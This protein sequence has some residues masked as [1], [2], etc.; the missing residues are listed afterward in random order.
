M[1][2]LFNT[3][4]YQP[5]FNA[6]ILIYNYIP[7][8]GITIIIL[9]IILKLI[10]WPLTKKSLEG[11][12]ALQTLQP[13]MQEIK[14]KYK[15]DKM[16]QSQA[17]MELYKTEKINPA[18]SCLPMLIQLPILW[19]VFRVFRNGFKEESM[20]ALYSFV[21]KP[22][23]LNP[24]MLNLSFFDLSKPNYLFAVLAGAAQYWQSKMMS[25]KQPPKNAGDGS[26]DEMMTSMMN[27][28]MLYFMP[29]FTV[30]IGLTL[31]GGLSL[32][33]M[34]STLLMVLQQ[35]ISFRKSQKVKVESQIHNEKG[36]S[37]AQTNF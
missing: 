18:S 26:R 12:K 2:S 14:K 22:E 9:T 33:W 32:Y 28:Q 10:L 19:A 29:A 4:L 37:C 20:N 3:I 25:T 1:G 11:Q 24:L 15:N 31:P 7:D 34:I 17:M 35:Y 23:M 36:K 27:K 5:I 16:A 21:S 30:F 8:I 6:L 13:K